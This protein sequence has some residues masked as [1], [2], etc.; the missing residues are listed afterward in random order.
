MSWDIQVGKDDFLDV[1]NKTKVG[2]RLGKKFIADE[3]VECAYKDGNLNI[4]VISAF[5]SIKGKGTGKGPALIPLR[6]YLRLREAFLKA[7]PAGEIVPLVFDSDKMKLT[8][9]TTTLSTVTGYD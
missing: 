2:K 8:I 5:H 4:L 3:T 1:L 9:G 7:P 6:T